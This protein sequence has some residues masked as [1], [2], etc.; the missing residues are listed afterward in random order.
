MPTLNLSNQSLR[1]L[2]A[3]LLVIVLGI[4]I[5]F[6]VE[7]WRTDLADRRAEEI[8]LS[9]FLRDLNS[10]AQI[11]DRKGDHFQQRI[12][13]INQ[14]IAH[15]NHS[16]ER[17]SLTIA[18]HFRTLSLG[19]GAT[20]NTSAYS[21]LVQEGR[22]SIIRDENLRNQI[23]RYYDLRLVILTGM[24]EGA[25]SL[26]S[27]FGQVALDDMFYGMAGATNENILI[28]DLTTTLSD[29]PESNREIL[30]EIGLVLPL[31]DIPRNPQFFGRLMRYGAV[32]DDV[33]NHQNTAR[34]ENT[35]LREAI[36]SYL[37]TF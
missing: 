17:D 35:E 27:D 13:A 30:R 19:S 9:A 15:L 16:A 14:L 6:Q 5:A 1:W 33:T 3:E 7:E 11:L 21:G 34:Q 37:L 4:L 12:E 32:S 20:Y 23:Q 26:R 31:E 24:E 18:K 22:L 36:E 29:A 8:S 28:V 2:L 25:E 10:D